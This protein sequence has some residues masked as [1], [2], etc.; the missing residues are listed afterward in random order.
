MA[1]QLTDDELFDRIPTLTDDELFNS[2]NT[3][4]GS[5][6]TTTTAKA[7]ASKPEWFMP[8]SKSEAALRGLINA[9][10]LGFGD[11]I[12]AGIRAPFKD[13]SYVQLRDEER[14]K[15]T[16]AIKTNPGS[17]LAGAI[18]PSI[19]QGGN[20]ANVARTA[21]STLI[22]RAAP[23]LSGVGTGALYGGLAGAGNSNSTNVTDVALDTVKG[24]GVGAASGA[25]TGAMTLPK[26]NVKPAAPSLES[27][28]FKGVAGGGAGAGGTLYALNEAEKALSSGDPINNPLGVFNKEIG[29]GAAAAAV[30]SLFI[31]GVRNAVS[32]VALPMTTV[33][34]H[35]GPSM[36]TQSS[37]ETLRKWLDDNSADSDEKRKKAMELTTT[38]AGRAVL[39][40]DR[41]DLTE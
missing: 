37:W 19:M 21:S 8:G 17:Y 16:D 35:G 40:E 31:P 6:N 34:K 32:K 5:I 24:A 15:E 28:I 14:Q 10:T 18:V 13:E 7:V 30:G 27:K 38:E 36:A 3:G 12:Q 4:T 1:K 9:A 39:D 23:V 22:P 29:K 25:L 20:V 26:A 33:A 2:I 11:E 41:F